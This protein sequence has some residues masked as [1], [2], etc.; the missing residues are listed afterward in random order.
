MHTGHHGRV[1]AAEIELDHRQAA[2]FDGAA[3]IHPALYGL[4]SSAA[5]QLGAVVFGV[6]AR[7]NQMRNPLLEAGAGVARTAVENKVLVDLALDEL[8]LLVQDRV[9][10]VLRQTR[11]ILDV[12]Q[13]LDDH[14]GSA[15]IDA[16]AQHFG[17]IGGLQRG[18][19]DG[20]LELDATKIEGK[21][22]HERSPGCGLSWNG[23]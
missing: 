21:V 11:H 2:I 5:D 22:C 13:C 17:A 19:D 3:D 18:N 10:G 4:A 12:G 7:F 15:R 1:R 6:L 16:L 9:L 23:N 8:I 20:V 14:A